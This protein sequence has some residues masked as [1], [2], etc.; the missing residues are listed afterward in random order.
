MSGI[1]NDLGPK[2]FQAVEAAINDNPDVPG[3]VRQYKP[4]FPIG[5]ADQNIARTYM[6]LSPVV[7]TYVPYLLIIDR[8][9]VIRAQYTGGEPFLA[10]ESELE[11]NIRSEVS[12][13]LS[14]NVKSAHKPTK[15]VARR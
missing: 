2:G 3:F 12:K 5:T 8:A 14:E 9:G 15:R 10:D 11:K 4:G 6:Q 13:L 7:R 1:Q